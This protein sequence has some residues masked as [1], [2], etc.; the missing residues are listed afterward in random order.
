MRGCLALMTLVTLWAGMAAAQGVIGSVTA[1]PASIRINADGA[2]TVRVR[3]RVELVSAVASSGPVASASGAIGA[4]PA[5]GGPLSRVVR[6]PGGG[7]IFVTLV[8][9]L[10]LDR[11]TARLI[12]QTGTSTYNRVFTT[13]GSTFPA[14]VRLQTSSGGALSLRYLD[15]G[16]DDGNRYRV[17]Q[18]GD[19]LSARLTLTT[20]GRG[21]FSGR[22]EVAGPV[23]AGAFRPLARVNRRLAGARRTILESPAL[24]TDRPGLYR[25][26]FVSDDVVPGQSRAPLPELTYSVVGQEGDDIPQTGV[27]LN[28]PQ[29]GDDFGRAT[30]FAWQPVD[31]ATRYRLE[32]STSGR[33]G[34]DTDMLA[35]VAVAGTSARLKPNTLM[36]LDGSASLY[37]RVIALDPGGAQIAASP[38]RRLR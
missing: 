16:F 3:W 4:G 1:Q 6:H 23:V 30:R 8:E 24:P 31:G 19:A 17:V 9:S 7:S 33:A 5:P 18:E 21:L 12:A 37:W 2:T 26:R 20:S 10:Y 32:F 29:P 28:S 36:R 38:L 22:W 14:S 11:T 15:L 13:P 35:A 25:V 34:F 27:R